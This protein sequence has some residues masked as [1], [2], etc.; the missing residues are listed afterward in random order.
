MG[1]TY[2]CQGAL[3]IKHSLE[4]VA[5]IVLKT[6]IQIKERFR[7]LVHF[8]YLY[9]VVF[10][11]LN[12]ALYTIST[13]IN[14]RTYRFSYECSSHPDTRLAYFPQLL[15]RIYAKCM[16]WSTRRQ[17]QSR[18]QVFSLLHIWK[19]KVHVGHSETRDWLQIDRGRECQIGRQKKR[20]H[21]L[22]RG[23][24]YEDSL[25]PIFATPTRAIHMPTLYIRVCTG[26]TSKSPQHGVF[27]PTR[28]STLLP[29]ARLINTRAPVDK[30][31]TRLS[32]RR[33]C[34]PPNSASYL[35]RD[36]YLVYSL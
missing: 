35:R 2:A 12:N 25:N 31:S 15:S 10:S 5:N 16:L 29:R 1:Y 36:T 24:W 14:A 19:K 17:Q 34:T 3:P 26:D 28:S 32:S 20:Q 13:R 7:Q 6:H 23:I 30:P 11:C 9:V 33:L 27:R 8:I 21:L 22:E 4:Y 18:N